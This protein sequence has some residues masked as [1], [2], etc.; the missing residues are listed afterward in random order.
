MVNGDIGHWGPS[1]EVVAS[2]SI[3]A[4]PKG[5]GPSGSAAEALKL[6]WASLGLGRLRGQ[7]CGQVAANPVKLFLGEIPSSG[8]SA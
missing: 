4:P 8:Q 1:W 2:E 7:V 3:G 5:C 6:F